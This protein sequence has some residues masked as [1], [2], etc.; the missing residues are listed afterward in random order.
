M[1]TVG[2][3]YA[4]AEGRKSPV[5]DGKVAR[6]ADGKELRY[7]IMLTKFEKEIA[8][9]VRFSCDPLLNLTYRLLRPSS[10]VFVGSMFYEVVE[11]H[12]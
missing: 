9:K 12:T 7:P 2:E 10:S 8:R 5:V 3:T 1:Y 4:H 11:S 6:N